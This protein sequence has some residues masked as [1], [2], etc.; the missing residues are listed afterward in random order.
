MK[1]SEAASFFDRV[2]IRDSATLKTLF[3]GQIDP[4][5]DS[6]RDANAAYRRI[7]SVRPG[8]AIPVS[9]SVYFFDA[10]WLIGTAETD[11]LDEQHRTKYVAQ[12]AYVQLKVSRLSGFLSGAVVVTLRASP[13]WVKDAGQEEV[14]SFTPQKFDIFLPAGA[15]VRVQDILWEAG[16]AY[17]V[18]APHEGASGFLVAHALKLDSVLPVAATLT[19]RSYNAVTGGYS[20]SVATAINAL[21]VRWQSLFV[22]GSQASERYQ[23]GDVALV[24]PAGTVASTQTLLTVS[25]VTYQALTVLNLSGAVVLHGRPV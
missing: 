20:N 9:R 4:Y 2:E 15:D 3:K 17:L 24:L 22:Y 5:D 25:G 23:E 19:T 21:P 16:V 1:L 6:K 10:H 13:Q 14:S 8:T 11:G 7:L 18:L 12:R